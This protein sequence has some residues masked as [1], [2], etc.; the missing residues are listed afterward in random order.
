MTSFFRDLRY[1]VRSFTQR[2]GFTTV[3]VVTLAL[4]IGS[5]VAIFSVANAVLF[6][7]LPYQDPERLVLVWNRSSNAEAGRRLVS[8]PDYLDYKDQATMLEDFAGA[9]AING[10]I[11]G[12]GRAEQLMMGWSTTNLF[13]VLGVRPILG[14]D[15]SEEDA[16]PIDP[17]DFLDPNV[18]IPPGHLIL[19]YG[20]WQQ[21]FGGDPQVLGRSVELDGHANT[22]VGVLPRDFRIYLP[23]DA[24]MPTNVDVW[25]V[26]PIDFDTNPREAEWLTVVARLKGGVTL[27]Q[28]QAEM[29]ALAARLREQYQF[30][31][32]AGLQIELN[33]MHN[34]VVRHVRLR[35]IALVVAGGFVLLIACFNVANLMLARAAGRQGEIAVRAA[36]GGGQGRIIR[37]ML[38]ESGVLSAAAGVAGLALAWGGIRILLAMRPENLPRLEQISLDARVL[39]FALGITLLSAV[40]FGLVPAL[41]SASPNLV[42]ALKERGSEMG[43]LKGNKLRMALVVVEVALSLVLLI[44]AGLLLRSFAALQQ[45]EPGF[46]PDNVLTFSVPLPA[47]EYREAQGRTDFYLRL[48]QRILA[49]P[50]VEAAGTVTPLP[51]AGGDQYYVFSYGPIDVTEDEWNRNKADYRWGLPGYHEA[52]GI[53]L[54][55]GRYMSE[56]D[57]QEGTLDIVLVDEALARKTWPDE[58]PVGKQLYVEH[59]KVEDFSL[60]R[61]LVQVVGVV[62]NVRSE[63]LA[64]DG[65]EAIYFPLRSFAYAPQNFAVRA[66]ANP[67]GLVKAVR[68]QVEAIDPDVPV[69]DMR[70]MQAYL[71]GAM[72]QTRF[73]LT[74]ITSFAVLALVLASIGLYGVISY[75]VHQRT[76]EIGVRMAFGAQQ[77]NILRLVVGQGMILALSGVGIGLLAASLF[78]RLVSSLFFDVTATDPAT[79]AGISILLFG[80]TTVASY[81]PARRAMKV[82]PLEALRGKLPALSSSANSG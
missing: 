68:S 3:V 60:E 80:I 79:F 26:L 64:A 15:F 14:R 34:D 70:L 82:D 23:A 22:V 57:N 6:Q 75:S 58:D 35:L 36:L 41:K 5:N 49:L 32:N 30:H 37:Q 65:R 4:G 31:A 17:K 9:F 73:T 29:D 27:D 50:G 53:R 19:S 33:S 11:T 52:M 42:N 21:R 12:E 1:A 44:G 10:T 38:I 51:L 78:F 2:I 55:A 46:Q 62:G 67:L 76:Q 56:A 61:I 16:T 24:G 66:S 59:F 69:A 48:R 63:S 72:A 13:K 8:G 20:L 74:L 25:R 43:G 40:V 28:A 81:V 18:K 77:G 71:T 47:F 7:P 45:V 39:W 54:L